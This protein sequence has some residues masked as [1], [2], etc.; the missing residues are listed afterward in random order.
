VTS[1]D[2]AGRYATGPSVVERVTLLPDDQIAAVVG[3]MPGWRDMGI[4]MGE[5]A[6][7]IAPVSKVE[8]AAGQ[9]GP[10][11]TGGHLK[12]SMEVRF[13][14]GPDPK[15]L[16]GS[17]HTVGEEGLSLFALIELGTEAHPI[18]QKPGGPLLHFVTHGHE[19]FTSHVNHPGT[20]KNPFA[21]RA[22]QQ[23]VHETA[24]IG[25]VSLK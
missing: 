21:E 12:G 9:F 18:D 6:K 2:S 17:T 19:V 4:R 23:I 3:G 10:Q 8:Q 7:A 14:F 11:Q 15:I 1:R 25:L 16:I 22:A 24:G 13:Q 20:K 5:R